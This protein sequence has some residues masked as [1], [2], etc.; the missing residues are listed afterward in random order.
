MVLR[1][2]EFVASGLVGDAGHRKAPGVADRRAEID[3]VGGIR[4]GFT[5]HDEEPP[6][7]A[8]LGVPHS[9]R[10]LTSPGQMAGL[11]DGKSTTRVLYQATTDPRKVR[12]GC[13][14]ARTIILD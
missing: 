2:H 4:Q 3:R 10:V 14:G 13:G 1:R 7:L 6:V 12:L 5:L 9:G 8:H 11:T